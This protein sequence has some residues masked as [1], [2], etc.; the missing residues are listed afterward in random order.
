MGIDSLINLIGWGIFLL[1]FVFSGLIGLIRGLRKST[2]YF[3]SY[4]IKIVVFILLS[5][6]IA[7]MILGM[8]IS[9]L[10]PN[11][12]SCNT[13]EELVRA[14]LVELQP[15]LASN[16]SIVASV[17][18]LVAMLIR[19]VVYL[20][21]IIVGSIIW[22]II[23][24]ILWLTVFKRRRNPESEEKP[25]NRHLLGGAVGL[26]KGIV[27]F[28][29]LLIPFSS[30]LAVM[31]EFAVLETK[32][33]PPSVKVE[34]V[35]N[36]RTVYADVN[37]ANLQNDDLS[38]ALNGFKNS[39]II[40]AGIKTSQPFS[41]IL[42]S[43]KLGKGKS[44]ESVNFRK[45]TVNVMKLVGYAFDEII[46]EKDGNLEFNIDGQKTEKCF[47][48]ISKSNLLSAGIPMIIDVA[49]NLDDVKDKIGT[50]GVDYPLDI[51]QIY[52]INWKKD[53][54]NL[55][56]VAGVGVDLYN[57]LD[58]NNQENSTQGEL[59]SVDSIKT[60]FN[61]LGDM[62]SITTL[63]PVGLDFALK[64]ES[65]KNFVPENFSINYGEETPN[66]WWSSEIKN[67][68]N[69][70]EGYVNL[71]I[72]EIPTVEGEDGKKNVDIPALLG[73]IT[74]NDQNLD[75]CISSVVSSR[76]VTIVLPVAFDYGMDLLDKQ[77]NNQGESYRELFEY[78][79]LTSEQWKND[80]KSLVYMAEDLYESKLLDITKGGKFGEINYEAFDD[81]ATQAVSLNLVSGHQDKVVG[82]MID[83][84][85]SD[86]LAIDKDS[87]DYNSVTSWP[88]EMSALVS[89][90]EA[91]A[92]IIDK[93]N[94]GEELTIKDIEF[95]VLKNTIDK[96]TDSKITVSLLPS[97]F[98]L[99]LDKINISSVLQMDSK[100][101]IPKVS[102][103]KTE[104]KAL[105]NALESI[106]KHD[107]LA[108]GFIKMN[109]NTVLDSQIITDL[110][111]EALTNIDKMGLD[112]VVVPYEKTDSNWYDK[113][114]DQ[115]GE[116]RLALN[117]ISVLIGDAKTM[118]E[119][120][121]LMSLEGIINLTD[122]QINTILASE[123]IYQT[124][125]KILIDKSSGTPII[126]PATAYSGD[127]IAREELNSLLCEIKDLDIVKNDGSINA[128]IE[129]L[130]KISE[131]TLASDILYA[132]ISDQI[133][134]QTSI[135]IPNEA[136][137]TN[138]Y[139]VGKHYINKSEII[140]LKKG[141]IELGI[142]S[143]G[144]IASDK[145]NAGL[146]NS[147]GNDT[148]GSMILRSTISKQVYDN[149]TEELVIPA[150]A[151]DNNVNFGSMKALNASELLGLKY[152]LVKLGLLEDGQIKTDKINAGLITKIADPSFDY[153]SA[154]GD[155]DNY[156]GSLILRFTITKVIPD[157]LK[158]TQLAYVNNDLSDSLKPSEIKNL[159]VAADTLKL[160]DSSNNIKDID[161][162]IINDLAELNDE[163][164]NS[165]FASIIIHSRVSE[166]IIATENVKIP[167]I[168]NVCQPMNVVK[169][170]IVI[171]TEKW[172]KTLE[173]RNLCLAVKENELVQEDEDKGGKFVELDALFID[174]FK[175]P[176]GPD[177][178]KRACN[179]YIFRYTLTDF[180]LTENNITCVEEMFVVT[181]GDDFVRKDIFNTDLEYRFIIVP[182]VVNTFNAVN[183][184]QMIKTD[185]LTGETYIQ[186]I[187]INDI[188]NNALITEDI[189]DE[190]FSEEHRSYSLQA[191]MS[192]SFYNSSN[193]LNII[194][195]DFD[196][197]TKRILI[198]KETR[199]ETITDVRVVD[200]LDEHDL[201]ITAMRLNNIGIRYNSVS[202]NQLKET[203][204]TLLSDII[205]NSRIM[206]ASMSRII[207]DTLE[208]QTINGE[209]LAKG[210]ED[211]T[212][213]APIFSNYSG[214]EEFYK[215]NGELKALLDAT[216]QDGFA[217]NAGDDVDVSVP[218]K[219]LNNSSI[220]RPSLQ[221]IVE[222]VLLDSLKGMKLFKA[223]DTFT[224]NKLS[225]KDEWDEEIVRLQ[226]IADASHIV[227]NDEGFKTSGFAGI[228]WGMEKTE[229]DTVTMV[230][231][232]LDNINNS[233][234]ATNGEDKLIT[235][236]F[237]N[238]KTSLPL[239]LQGYASKP[240]GDATY[241]DVVENIR[242][243][244]P[245]I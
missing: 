211:G 216:K 66:E 71:G 95:D 21:L 200:I 11:Y 89:T 177:K 117:A 4:I 70:Y 36:I 196:F 20:L 149:K 155:D 144:D 34:E 164:F 17:V 125:S 31:S 54:K 226:A 166:E 45:E 74:E 134:L 223:G 90:V 101:T 236:V 14:V 182:E 148:V 210:F 233:K 178:I 150:K 218:L 180:F 138:E 193:K 161:L 214:Y 188:L 137:A 63:I 220:L 120:K 35:A 98:Q 79:N 60:L 143:N 219:A 32:M 174:N 51:N 47:E 159:A 30:M 19:S 5:F 194:E 44:K 58:V 3:V 222:K 239:A 78:T 230:G 128:N 163:K 28:I 153:V 204:S 227:M 68:G 108:I 12:E 37:E 133:N 136:Y 145:I 56:K 64:N 229:K 85:P 46:E 192:S 142:I 102:D 65:I 119:A 189:I 243:N 228:N 24:S 16:E 112:M 25:R 48:Y 146:L 27:A 2:V 121:S 57:Q 88:D 237:N 82:K 167:Y 224:F 195:N 59:V 43:F 190:V 72:T 160:V 7:S 53:L 147:V 109:P 13:F 50:P 80:F 9:G 132:T 111:I 18:S 231:V 213:Y 181:S 205:L 156:E 122:A 1:I 38:K 10:V 209:A 93:A 186:L 81:L 67:L 198:N 40:Q 183:K 141:I 185:P 158:E 124:S 87:I 126:I 225:T 55:G 104:G 157:S 152:S 92:P 62:E 206:T 139:E 39:F 107:D 110:S 86:V 77:T 8:N 84:I 15:G 73:K 171:S 197:A 169:D 240:T 162:N 33:N 41:D 208:G 154:F 6:P 203:D 234:L 245:T 100:Y 113:A 22:Y 184:L 75:N 172:I 96:A 202:Y 207:N 114:P 215:T 173:I 118:E 151:Y 244:Y 26:C 91:A 116:I 42:Y 130:T 103:W 179:S 235:T 29:V 99:V 170:D 129:C 76:L 49:L 176:D 106:S 140:A 83:F 168:E 232:I 201:I 217:Y 69:I 165:V 175:G 52:D 238:F 191:T 135:I 199:V 187:G 105:V 23:T 241:S 131:E 115:K 221:K 242:N 94:S 127:L 97:V 123:I 61:S 212:K